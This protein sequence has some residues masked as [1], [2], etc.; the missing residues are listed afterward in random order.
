MKK[1][2]TILFVL[3]AEL[4]YVQVPYGTKF[5][6]GFAEDCRVGPVFIK[7]LADSGH[8][9]LWQRQRPRST[10]YDLMAQVL[11]DDDST[12]TCTITVASVNQNSYSLPNLLTLAGGGFAV[13]WSE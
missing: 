6:I 7:P 12:A 5:H 8:A 2:F 13:A 3:M 10:R 9:V 1:I 11:R 4:V